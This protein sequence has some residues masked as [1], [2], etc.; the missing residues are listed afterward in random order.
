MENLE[1]LEGRFVLVWYYSVVRTN[2]PA[3]EILTQ[4]FRTSTLQEVFPGAIVK[5]RV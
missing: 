1:T 3:R 5:S 4:D 2:D